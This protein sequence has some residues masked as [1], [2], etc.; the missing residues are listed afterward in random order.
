M[1]PAGLK[2]TT[3]ITQFTQYLA[4]GGIAFAVDFGLLVALTELLGINYLVSASLSFIAGLAVN[5][6]LCIWFVFNERALESRI[7]EFLAFTLIGIGGLILNLGI[8]AF[9][10]SLIGTPY[11]VAKLASAAIVLLFN[12]TLRR[13]LLFSAASPFNAW[14]GTLSASLVTRRQ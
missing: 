8:L 14:V 12:F 5:Y 9:M 10:V 2:L 4:V 3:I 1:R 7:H 6:A 11:T 13:Q